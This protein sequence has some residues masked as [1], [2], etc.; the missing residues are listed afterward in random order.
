[1]VRDRLS[2]MLFLGFEFGDVTPD[3]NTIRHFRDRLTEREVLPV[4]LQAFEEELSNHSL[5]ARGGQI[6]DGS[7]VSAP[8]QRLTKEEK[9]AIEEGKTAR[10]IWAEKPNK[11]A[12]KDVDAR[13]VLRSKGKAGTGSDGKTGMQ[14]VEATHGC[15]MS[16]CADTKHKLIRKTAVTPANVH[17]SRCFEELVDFS[18]TSKVVHADS[19]YWAAQ[20]VCQI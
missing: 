5:D 15:K 2:W 6:I 14:R 16:V 19:A 9:E 10:E 11:A 13:W 17:D 18:N 3:G 4:L 7:L 20:K 1:M 12:Q 8:K